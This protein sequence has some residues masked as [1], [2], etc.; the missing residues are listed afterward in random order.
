[1]QNPVHVLTNFAEER[2]IIAELLTLERFT[3]YVGN[4]AKTLSWNDVYRKFRH[5]G[6]ITKFYYPCN[7]NQFGLGYAAIAYAEESHAISAARQCNGKLA[8]DRYLY[9]AASI[10]SNYVTLT[11][12]TLHVC[13]FSDFVN[14]AVLGDVFKPKG[15]VQHIAIGW[16]VFGY[17]YARVTFQST[18]CTEVALH[19][20]NGMDLGDGFKLQ[21][22][23]VH[24]RYIDE[25]ISPQQFASLRIIRRKAGYVRISGLPT[26]VTEHQL[27]N[28][29]GSYGKLT[30]ILILRCFGRSMGYGIIHF[31]TE[32]AARLAIFRHNQ[33]E[34]LG[35]TLT[36][37]HIREVWR[38]FG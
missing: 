25:P 33:V 4:L 34:K 17:R 5:H 23:H 31:E 8:W 20:C 11:S 2:Q 3:I 32:A 14:E 37:E 36:L 7:A 18:L 29:F 10:D 13:N 26:T 21:I 19:E 24:D 28:V 16:N 22:K 6:Y 9:V 12:T 38:P 35:L 27:R 15:Q 30:E 1:M